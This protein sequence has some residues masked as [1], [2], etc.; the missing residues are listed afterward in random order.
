M[1]GEALSYQDKLARA[2]LILLLEQRGSEQEQQQRSELLL[3]QAGFNAG[4]IA[5]LLG[6]QPGAVRMAL[7]RARTR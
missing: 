2:T 3:A 1:A 6:K 4:E 7:K 5:D